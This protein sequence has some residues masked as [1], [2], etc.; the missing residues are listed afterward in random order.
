MS[1]TVAAARL[2]VRGIVQGVG[3]RP[4]VHRLADRHGLDG[5]VRNTSGDVEIALEGD[6]G[7]IDAFIA[8]LQVRAPP[9]AR[10]DQVFVERTDAIGLDGFAI[11]ESESSSLRRQLVAPDVAICGA[12]E[13][14]LFDPTNRR[15]RYPFITC[16]DCGPRYSVI[17]A[18]PYDRART[19]MRAFT[20]CPA[21][22]AEYENPADRRYHSETNSCPACGPAIRC[23]GPSG[24]SLGGDPIGV[25]GDLIRAGR[26]VAVRGVGGF[27]LAVDATNEDAVSRLR[28]RKR[29]DGKPLAVMVASLGQVME[30][31]AFSREDAAWLTSGERPIVILRER[32]DSLIAPSVGVGLGTVGVMLAYTPLHLLLLGEIGRPLVMTS[33]N[34]SG[35]PLASTLDEAMR[36]LSDIADAY[37]THDREIVARIDDSVLRVAQPSPIL[38]RRGRG[39][40]PV[41]VRLP[42]PTP[43]PLVAVGPHLKNTFAL[44]AGDTAFLS[45]HIGDLESLNTEETWRATYDSLSRMFDVAPRIAVRDLHPAYLS[46]HIAERLPVER[47][48]AVQH[49]H[50]HVA[51]VAAEHAVTDPV[52]GVAFDGTGYG[53]D[54]HTWGAEILLADLT[55]FRRLA[56]LRYV[57]LAGGDLAARAPW[58]SVLGYES[59]GGVRLLPAEVLATLPGDVVSVV[60]RQ[61]QVRLNTPIASSMGRLFDAAAAVLGVCVDTQ[62]EGEAG[63]R[64][65]ALA[66]SRGGRELPFDVDDELY[67]GALVLDPLPLLT[68]LSAELGRGADPAD[69]AA[70]F[71]ASIAA[72]TVRLLQAI[73]ERQ[74]IRRVAL[75]GGVFQN[76]R[77][78]T[79]F[80]GRLATAGLDVLL[81]R[82]LP[83]N[84][85]AISYGQAVV[86]AARLRTSAA[87]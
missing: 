73:A 64:L 52:I 75:A 34:P 54:G 70:D 36:S 69:L 62:F 80:V 30:L 71:H 58:R 23:L 65:E 35:E 3:F 85:G 50:A 8:E 72:G 61:L 67:D 37:L 74:G 49:H 63:M 20:Q 14:E 38:L 2:H 13:R 28:A 26:I 44:A 21:C 16:T 83:S 46:T 6:S 77:L 27:H 56:H 84:D 33:G 1:A 31:A 18:M 81:P 5:W 47:V 59:L 9:L 40:A 82:Q 25:V 43:E 15:Y 29:R 45:P 48:L 7:A 68:E 60:R 53:D 19:S 57:P 4:F 87:A 76:A 55:E 78:L 42:V 86:G 41:P 22:R 12:C 79:E 17:E 51:A 11:A 10:I 32:G 24:E 66:G 39:F